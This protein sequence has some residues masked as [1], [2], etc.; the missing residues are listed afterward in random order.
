LSKKKHLFQ[1]FATFEKNAVLQ[2]KTLELQKR[3][4]RQKIWTEIKFLIL[5]GDAK[6]KNE[7]NKN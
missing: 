3:V 7:Q 5:G 6:E 2:K 4:K 1:R